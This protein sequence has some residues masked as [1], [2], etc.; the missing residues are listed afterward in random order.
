[1]LK[2]SKVKKLVTVLATS[3]L[4]TVAR[5]KAVG[6]NPGIAVEEAVD[7]NPGSN[8]AR[9]FYIR[10]HIN[11]RKKSML[12]LFDSDSE[13]N[14]IYLTFAKELGLPIRQTE[15]KAQKID[16][17]MLDIFRIVVVAFSIA[18]KTNQ[19]KF[20]KKTFLLA[21]VSPE[22]VLGMPFLTLSGANVNFLDQ[23]L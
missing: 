12:A 2:A 17:T 22:I 6:E 1:M 13:V 18:D 10:Y 8:L 20:F 3:M 9:V 15:V 21:N 23:E 19:I 11:F 7:E 14:T 16:G 4:V 5:K